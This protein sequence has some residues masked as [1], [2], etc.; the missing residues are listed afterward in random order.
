MSR[1][2][3][4]VL[5]IWVSACG[6]VP[7]EE[8]MQIKQLVPAAPLLLK[9]VS[10]AGCPGELMLK[11]QRWSIAPGDAAAI[12]ITLLSEDDDPVEIGQVGLFPAVQP[13]PAN[14]LLVLPDA[15]TCDRLTGASVQL[16]LISLRP[17]SRLSN[18]SGALIADIHYLDDSNDA[19]QDFRQE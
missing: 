3:L 15:V 18:T 11:L 8:D 12:N 4:V 7:P 10:T 16:Q 2:W 6:G 19:T 9:P 13:E 17:D 14:F 1:G 5:L